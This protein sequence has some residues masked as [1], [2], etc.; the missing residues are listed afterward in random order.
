[1][2]VLEAYTRQPKGKREARRLKRAGEVL[3]VVYGPATTPVPI[4]IK[5]AV[6]EKIF[7]SLSETEPIQLIIKSENEEVVSQKLVFLKSIQRDKIT[8]VVVHVDF[9]EPMK[10]H[11][12]RINVPI[13][14]VGKPVGVE[15]GGF[16]ELV[17]EELPVETDPDKVPKE[18]EVDV[19]ELDLGDSIHVRDLKLPEGVKCLLSEDEVVALVMV[20]KEVVLEEKAAGAEEIEEP[21][22]R[23]KGKK[24]EEEEEEK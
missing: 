11:K 21:E 2:I 20:P 13:K 18:I 23:R 8:E 10:G 5:R 17:H 24:E 16:L 15:K 12:M 3:G 4:R 22:V 19:S 7:S 9:Y 1:M 6:F 14:V